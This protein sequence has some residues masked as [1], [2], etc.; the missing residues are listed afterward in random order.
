MS[1]A[2]LQFDHR[3]DVQMGD[4]VELPPRGETTPI[5]TFKT[6]T[7]RKLR[8]VRLPG[9]HATFEVID[10]RSGKRCRVDLLSLFERITS[11]LQDEVG[12]GDTSSQPEQ[13]DQSENPTPKEA[14]L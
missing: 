14:A 10:D 5:V 2:N 6:V 7:G 13:S 3:V 1:A 9:L 4:V 8:V 11:D 12:A